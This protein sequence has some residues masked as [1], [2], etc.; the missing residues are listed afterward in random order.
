MLLAALARA[1]RVA[2]L[3]GVAAAPD[4]TAELLPARLSSGQRRTLEETG[5]VVLP[6]D[7]DPA[8]YVYTKALVEDGARHLLLGAPIPLDVPVRLLHGLA[9]ASVPWQLSLRLA[10]RLTGRDVVVTLVKGGDHR[11]SSASDLARLA[12]TL[13]ALAPV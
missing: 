11:L 10:E 6:S 1:E 12:Q 7:Y 13:D 2:A 3:V 5:A 4:F 8:G 9:D